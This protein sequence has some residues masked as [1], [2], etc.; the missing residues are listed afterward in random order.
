[1]TKDLHEVQQ[2]LREALHPDLHPKKEEKKE[3]KKEKKKKVLVESTEFVPEEAA[4]GQDAFPSLSKYF[5]SRTHVPGKLS[6]G[7]YTLLGTMSVVIGDE[8]SKVPTPRIHLNLKP[9]GALYGEAT[10]V[11]PNKV[12]SFTGEWTEGGIAFH[13]KLGAVTYHFSL[14]KNAGVSRLEGRETWTDETGKDFSGSLIMDISR[15]VYIKDS[16]VPQEQ[17]K[18]GGEQKEEKSDTSVVDKEQESEGDDEGDDDDEDEE[19]DEEEDKQKKEEKHGEIQ[20]L[21]EHPPSSQSEESEDKKK[22]HEDIQV[23]HE[24]P[25]LEP[26]D[27]GMKVE[28][29]QKP[30]GEEMKEDEALAANVEESVKNGHLSPS[31]KQH[32]EEI[33]KDMTTQNLAKEQELHDHEHEAVQMAS[34][35]ARSYKAI[36]AKAH[37][38]SPTSLLMKGTYAVLSGHTYNP[39]SNTQHSMPRVY[40]VLHSDGTL[41]GRA[42]YDANERHG[43]VIAALHGDWDGQSVQFLEE[44]FGNHFIFTGVLDKHT[45]ELHGTYLFGSKGHGEFKCHIVRLDFE[46][47]LSDLKHLASRYK[48]DKD[49]HVEKKIEEVGTLTNPTEELDSID[50]GLPK[51]VKSMDQ[52]MGELKLQMDGAD[53]FLDS[54]TN[55]HP[56]KNWKDVVVQ[57]EIDE[58]SK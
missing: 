41:T 3:K 54:R 9:G 34:S 4:N 51:E 13:H 2:A 17:K 40:F 33:V 30:V 55:I 56:P 52:I 19:E 47:D 27:H 15:I 28:S 6:H 8:A 43:E 25:P 45:S 39:V 10:Y 35:D 57:R 20:V 7:F 49:G 36:M 24:H 18:H 12:V 5:H 31:Q 23:L 53:H 26:N 21:H 37:V 46:E 11:R 1:M 16:A 32:L 44:A 58:I 14:D 22:D 29:E 48:V 42:E 38:K 50:I